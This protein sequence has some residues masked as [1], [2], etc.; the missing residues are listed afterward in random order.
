MLKRGE[1]MEELDAEVN[2]VN[3]CNLEYMALEV[4]K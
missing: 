2:G 3:R 4:C 1:M